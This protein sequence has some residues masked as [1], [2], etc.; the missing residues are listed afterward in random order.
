[1]QNLH[2]LHMYLC[3]CRKHNREQKSQSLTQWTAGRGFRLLA[4]CW[5][6][7]DLQDLLI[8]K[9]LKNIKELIIIQFCFYRY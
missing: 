4:I 2:T 7:E 3:D 8:N 1:M 5:A 6:G 9:I